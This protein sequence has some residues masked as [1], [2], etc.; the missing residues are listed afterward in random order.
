MPNLAK[1]TILALVASLPSVAL[2]QWYGSMDFMVPTRSRSAADVFQRNITADGT[3][4]TENLL[5]LDLD[6]VSGGRA[7]VGFQT[8]T[9][10][11]EGSFLFTDQWEFSNEV[12]DANGLLA[13][14]F[15]IV[16]LA[17]NPLTDFNTYA[18]I[19]YKTELQSAEVNFTYL[20]YDDCG[21]QGI[22]KFGMRGV[23]IDE[24]F[25][26]GS[27]NETD[28]MNVIFNTLTSSVNNRLIGPQIGFRGFTPV[29]GGFLAANAVGMLAYN[30][31]DR[32]S[33][34]NGDRVDLNTS[35]ASVLGELAIEYLA[36]VSPN[37]IIR[38][39]YQVLGATNI[40]LAPNDPLIT[41]KQT[42]GVVY[43]TPYLGVM[44]LR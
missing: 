8:E 36:T 17:P 2:G 15:S 14:P 13:S 44:I 9:H 29:P 6:C 10:G 22:C 26:Y 33:V 18:A 42:D 1:V 41:D 27:V 37:A 40:G 30:D 5:S 34:L 12:A 35:E 31:I 21:R 4:G 3:V 24:M 39:G 38:V 43:G 11:I 32:T 19:T 20:V 25:E 7:T 28:P 23:A 16:G